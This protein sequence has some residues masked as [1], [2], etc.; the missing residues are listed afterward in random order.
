MDA[1]ASD[2]TI[3]PSVT[4]AIEVAKEVRNY[5]QQPSMTMFD[6]QKKNKNGAAQTKSSPERNQTAANNAGG[7]NA[8]WQS[9]ALH[10]QTIQPKLTINQPGDV[11]EQEADQ[12]AEQ[13]MTAPTLSDSPPRIQ[14]RAENATAT[15]TDIPVSVHQTLS[16]SGK[17]LE[18][19]VR[20]EMEQRFEH[21]FS[22]V[23]IHAGTSAAQ[24]AND[25]N[26]HAYTVGRNI[27]FGAGKY[28]PQHP[29]G[30]KLLAHELTH[31]VQQSAG[32]SAIQRSDR[33]PDE[34]IA[35]GKEDE[36]IKA[37]A[38]RGIA[39][40]NPNF[41]VHEVM[42]RLVKNYGLNEHFELNGS[43][44]EKDKKGVEVKLTGKGV[45]TTGTIV[46][47][48][49]VLQ[50]IANG[51]GAQVV[52]E[53]EAQIGKIDTAR[54][55]VDYVFIMGADAPKSNNKFYAHAK[56]FFKAEFPTAT[57]FED[58]RD[59]EGINQQINAENKPVANLYIVSHA[60]PDGTMQFSLNQ[61][62]Q[63]PGQVQFS[64]LKEA[65]ENQSLTQPKPDLVGFWTNV[66]IRGCNLGRSEAML[67]QTKEA[68]GGEVRV[69]APTH[70]QVYS[71]GKESMGGAFYEEP[72]ISKLSDDEAFKRIKAKPEYAFITDWDA[73]RKKL[74]RIN[75]N[76]AE[77]V[78]E[79]EFPA[80]GK[81]MALLKSQQ[82]AKT[83]ANFTFGSS[84]IEGDQTL[85]TYTSKQPTK[86]GDIEIAQDTP[87]TDKEAIEDA[88][89]KV[90]RPDAYAY[91]VRRV[92]SGVNLKVIVDIQQTEWVLYHAEMHKQ[93]KGFNPSTGTKPWYADTDD[94]L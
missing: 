88:R 76:D 82:G 30:Q 28:A 85:F 69:I 40:G 49:E 9:L 27:V 17:S 91:K 46:G 32:A 18:P 78:Y 55:A 94:P 15:T 59:L 31:V 77:I 11:Y 41:A 16:G 54:G 3:V 7:H 23:K 80:K 57:M 34:V 75:T 24:S 43:R 4:N 26:A 25:L 8:S 50:R 89:N 6:S 36:S 20:Q 79:G 68:F 60:H 84:R 56:Q 64:E 71:G 67:E 29:S 42:W 73:M 1:A 83:A 92:Q 65:N 86:F 45:R 47:G 72:G 39:S 48:E 2:S 52:K 33:D 93:G 22:Q 21:D 90:A 61:A 14:R 35:M 53:I 58:V 51:Q 38:K 87:P 13:V 37:R 10:P 66:M 5:Q 19:S 63:T 44:Y 62:D 81:E 70:E 12:M 74:K